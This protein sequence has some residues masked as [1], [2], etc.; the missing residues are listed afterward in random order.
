M[1]ECILGSG[2]MN[3][4]N[5]GGCG[6]KIDSQYLD[7]ILQ[8]FKFKNKN[9]KVIV[10]LDSLDDCAVYDNG[11]DEY[12]LFTNDF[13][14]P[15]LDDPYY[16]GYIAAANALSDI[17]A[18][19]G[20]PLIANAIFGFPSSVL[21]KLDIEKIMKGGADAA[22]FVGC[23]IVGGHTIENPQ[24][25]YGLS[26]LGHVN[27]NNLKL[28]SGA[29]DGDYIIL[30]KPIGSGIFSNALKLGLVSKSM[31]DDILPQLIII[32]SIGYEIGKIEAV[33][34]LTDI[35][36]FGLLGHLVEVIENS[37]LSA[38]LYFGNIP[39]YEETLD[40]I[41]MVISPKSGIKKNLKNLES[42]IEF[43]SSLTHNQ[44]LILC[45]P[46]SN[47]GLLIFVKE[48]GLNKVQD[49]MLANSNYQYH[50]IGRVRQKSDKRVIV[51]NI[52]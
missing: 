40:L 39:F 25:F 20:K 30:T 36:G 11:G 18:M 19:G 52:I 33:T 17:Y 41:D 45:D 7:S 42:K 28:N 35:T 48:E 6:C 34:A 49:A 29:Q 4:T 50:I 24:P 10:N 37:N 32:N 46:Q 8:N 13:F 47:G 3:L 14:S 21:S 38:E 9:K 51:K 2:L 16:Y 12:L 26:V 43:E 27:K 44:K 31:Y 22:E 1:E 15:L 23:N 5:A